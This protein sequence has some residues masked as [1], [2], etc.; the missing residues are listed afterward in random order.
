MR[1]AMSPE[2]AGTKTVLAAFE[3]ERSFFAVPVFA[4]WAGCVSELREAWERLLGAEVVTCVREGNEI[5]SA[6]STAENPCRLPFLRLTVIGIC[7]LVPEAEFW[8]AA[9]T[10]SRKILVTSSLGVATVLDSKI[11]AVLLLMETTAGET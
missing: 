8:E 1:A 4:L 10:S 2:S 9:G 7:V 5:R 3:S 11:E 6:E